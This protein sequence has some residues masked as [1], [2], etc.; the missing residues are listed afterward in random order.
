M[1]TFDKPDSSPAVWECLVGGK[2]AREPRFHPGRSQPILE[3][4]Q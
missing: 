2:R 1:N 4:L 3:T